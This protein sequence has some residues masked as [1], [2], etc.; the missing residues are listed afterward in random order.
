MNKA[1]GI[2]K[3]EED[4]KQIE[5]NFRGRYKSLPYIKIISIG[6]NKKEMKSKDEL[7][8]QIKLKM[9]DKIIVLKLLIKKSIIE[10]IHKI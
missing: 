6:E 8:E 4:L 5:N 1:T 7:I 2:N 9:Q 3:G 10:F